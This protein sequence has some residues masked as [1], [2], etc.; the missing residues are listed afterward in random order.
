MT[1]VGLT[2]GYYV[3]LSIRFIIS[4]LATVTD[5]AVLLRQR[6]VRA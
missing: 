5:V 1:R 4:A 3:D 2:L 6:G